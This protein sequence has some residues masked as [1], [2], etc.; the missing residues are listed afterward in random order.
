MET[1][2][3]KVINGYDTTTDAAFDLAV[4]AANKGMSKDK[5]EE[6]VDKYTQDIV[7][8]DDKLG[9]TAKNVKVTVTRDVVVID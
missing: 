3:K 5:I 1:A 2:L 4:K 9:A 8:S 7:I 6:L